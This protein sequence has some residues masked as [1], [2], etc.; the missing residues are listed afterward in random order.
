M[1]RTLIALLLLTGFATPA[2]TQ[3]LFQG[4][5]DVTVVDSQSRPVPGVLIEIAGASTQSQTTDEKGEA[6]F[7]NLAPGRY[8][9][10]ATLSGFQPFV[11]EAIEVAAGTS[12]P[13]NVP[14]RVGGVTEAVQ[15]VAETPVIDPAKQ[16]ITTS[17]SY[18]QLQRLPSAR[19]PWVMLQ[20]VP[21]V[22][23][24]RVNVGGAESGQQSNVLAKGAGVA[25]NTWNLD[26]IPVTD[27]AATGSSPTYYNFD[28]FQ[29]MS[30]TTGG[31][32]ATNPTA[33]AQLNM[34][35]KSGSN[36]FS[37][38]AHYYG[39]GE[40]LQSTNLPD[41]L[42]PLAGESGKGNRMK[43]LT[44]VGFDLGGPVVRDRLWVWGSYGYTD[45]TLYTLNGDP[46]RTEL[47]NVAVKVTGQL[48]PSIRPEFLFFRGNKVKTGRGASPLRA[49][50][51]TWDQTGPTPLYKGQV[52]MTAGNN[53]FVTARGAYVGNGFSLTP[54]GG[55]DVTGYRDANRVRRGSYVFYET[56]RP[57]YSFLADGNWFRGRHEIAFGGSWRHSKDDERQDFPGSGA[58]N[59]H[60][61]DFETSRRITAY[62]YRPFFASSVG[63]N[64]S[65]YVGDTIRNGRLTAQLSLRYDRTHASM[66]ESTQAAIPGFP[67]LLPSI[68]APEQEKMIDLS[69][70][71]PRAGVTYGLDEAG[72]TQVRASY[73]LFGSQLG[74]GT[75]QSFSAASQAVL[76]YSA[77]DRNFN[78]VA[79]PDELEELITFGGVDP[80]NPGSGVNFNRINPDLKAPK[81]HE[82]VLGLDRE[83]MP[84]FGVSASVSWRRFTDV[85]WSGYDMSQ[86][87][88]VYPLVGVTRADY[89]LEG[90][91]E[92]NVPGVGPY[93]QEYYA[94]TDASLPPGN[95]SE[96]RNRPD[97]S[98]DYLGFELQAVKRLSNRWMA[99]VGFSSN[100]HT[101]NFGSDAALQDPGTSTTWPNIDGG[102][103]VTGTSG[104]G[105][106]EIFLVLPRYQLSA[107]GLYQFN[108]GINVAASLNVR[109]GYGMPFFEPVE[110]A[111]PLLPEKRVLLV[112]PRES[113]LPAVSVLDLRGEKSFMFGSR[114]LALSLDLF[115]VFNSAT[116]LGRQYDVTTTGTTGFNQPLEIMNP[117]LLRFGVRFQF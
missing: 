89:Q 59:L 41:E 57:D 86:L 94:P 51:T 60:A 108:Y 90:V 37:G 1:R 116:V 88:T 72:R 66:L 39:A 20:T 53:V 12:V 38:A 23:V 77:V 102:A 96:F 91:V 45:S 103:F 35:F 18:D 54:Q 50:A 10:S 31:A 81:T 2:F 70:W 101:E 61:S 85:I 62:L 104:S 43:E 87:I 40:S 47:A 106:S 3:T 49:A 6:H 21:G 75:V 100:R 97:Y 79:D 74:T 52:N 69:L 13:L 9:V 105:K 65:F 92:G 19:D 95:G 30:V 34:Q 16:T 5:I 84:Q 55:L 28:M 14:L 63:V 111:D 76:I 83:L 27:L 112:D 115:N 32:S 110:S 73:G 48:N 114:E 107:S 78:N 64:Q 25:E 15:V 93:R 29:E 36:V 42:L 46:D 67:T 33:G 24:D 80:A 56:K 68:T 98:Q 11:A 99:R 7:L 58:D 8:R 109:E 17:I 71:S 82:V 113:R 4:R 22:V 117:R 44:D 26:G